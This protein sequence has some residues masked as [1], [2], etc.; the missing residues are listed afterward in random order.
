MVDRVL[1]WRAASRDMMPLEMRTGPIVAAVSGAVERFRS[2]VAPDEMALS[3]SIDSRL[4]VSHDAAALNA[5]VLNLLTNAYKYTGKDKRIGIGIRDEAAHVVIEVSDNGIGLTEAEAK[6]VFQ[7]FYR[8]ENR[9]G[10][11]GT[12]LGLAIARHL[13]DRHGGTISVTSDKGIRTAFTI[14]LPSAPATP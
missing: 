5:V 6:L 14:R 12:G 7:P 13:V 4:P 9:G 10:T 3:L 11:S 8:A 2:M 1:T